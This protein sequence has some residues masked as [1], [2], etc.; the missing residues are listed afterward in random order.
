MELY[1]VLPNQALVLDLL[2]FNTHISLLEIV[3]KYSFIS[4]SE[5]KAI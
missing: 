4:G 5:A 3:V 1:K 2:V